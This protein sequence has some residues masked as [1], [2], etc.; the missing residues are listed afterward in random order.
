MDEVTARQRELAEMWANGY[1]HEEVG[2]TFGITARTSKAA[3]ATVRYKLGLKSRGVGNT[4]IDRRELK[5]ALARTRRR[6]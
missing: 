2:R 3:V 5:E 4:Q 1:T 6:R